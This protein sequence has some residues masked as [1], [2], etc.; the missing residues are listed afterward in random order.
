MKKQG[1]EPFR[2]SI[3]HLLDSSSQKTNKKQKTNHNTDPPSAL[4]KTIRFRRTYYS[5]E[6]CRQKKIKCDG[7]RPICSICRSSD[8]ICDYKEIVNADEFAID[9]KKIN[10]KLKN[11]NSALMKLR[12]CPNEYASVPLNRLYSIKGFNKALLDLSQFQVNTP[13]NSTPQN[14]SLNS[15]KDLFR[16]KGHISNENMAIDETD[17]SRPSHNISDS[18]HALLWSIH[19]ESLCIIAR[20]SICLKLDKL[21]LPTKS[22]LH[23]Q[24]QIVLEYKRRVWWLVYILNVSYSYAFGEINPI[25]NNNVF[26][27]LPSSRT[28]YQNNLRSVSRNKDNK[29]D[30]FGMVVRSYIELGMVSDFINTYSKRTRD[31]EYV[32]KMVAMK[33]RLDNYQRSHSAFFRRMGLHEFPLDMDVDICK[34]SVNEKY[35][36]FFCSGL[37]YRLAMLLL[38]SS[39]III[40]SLDKDAL[41][42][43]RK[44]KSA[45]I[46]ISIDI[47]EL[48]KWADKYMDPSYMNITVFYSA[49]YASSI[50][51]NALKLYSHEKHSLIKTCYKDLSLLFRSYS[52]HSAISYDFEAST[53]Y[54]H[55]IYLKSI[56][57]NENLLDHF[58]ELK[59]SRLEKNDTNIW[60]VRLGTPYFSHV[61]CSINSSCPAYKYIFVENWVKFDVVISKSNKNA[62]QLKDFIKNKSEAAKSCK[63]KDISTKQKKIEYPS[64]CSSSNGTLVSS[65]PPR[66]CITESDSLSCGNSTNLNFSSSPL[67]QIVNQN[68]DSSPVSHR[69]SFNKSSIFNME[70]TNTVHKEFEAAPVSRF[71]KPR[72]PLLISCPSLQI[73][74]ENIR[75]PKSH[76]LSLS[77]LLGDGN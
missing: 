38:C 17:P 32:A 26:V 50:L 59:A 6:P 70:E 71:S 14:I 66:G 10:I 29:C 33:K 23:I 27:S 24:D 65:S 28:D 20:Y 51:L 13:S 52:A 39:D 47:S 30:A 44:A 2:P 63:S 22:R 16:N 40:C 4:F 64:D 5:C 11:I 45:S 15:S 49:N 37:T 46:D 54:N 58:P 60:F 72:I 69:Q 53:R 67:N 19:D 73:S 12:S 48:L 57:F 35:M 55:S 21:D 56:S 43:S 3:K 1:K 62:I 74:K 61:C 18:F 34:K 76:K 8:R 68:H 7:Y 36:A 42:R 77:F 31:G 75:S 9:V 41:V 25:Q